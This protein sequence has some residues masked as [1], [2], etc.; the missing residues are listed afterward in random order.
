MSY[1]LLNSKNIHLMNSK[2][3]F[4]FEIMF[5]FETIPG[6]EISRE[7]KIAVNF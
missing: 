1:S 7:Q 5:L 3:K 2:E 6:T 4:T